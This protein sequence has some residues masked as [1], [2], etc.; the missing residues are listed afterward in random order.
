MLQF[1]A[2]L[3]E[4]EASYALGSILGEEDND[5]SIRVLGYGHHVGNAEGAVIIHIPHI[6]IFEFGL[7][8]GG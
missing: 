7:Y 3:A 8:F 1:V 5:I 6:G 4:G 2:H